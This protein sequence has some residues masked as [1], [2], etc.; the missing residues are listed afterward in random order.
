MRWSQ[1]NSQGHR[2]PLIGFDRIVVELDGGDGKNLQ[3]IGE[4]IWR[5][6]ILF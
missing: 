3:G 6:P 5:H 1:E 4:E 2:N